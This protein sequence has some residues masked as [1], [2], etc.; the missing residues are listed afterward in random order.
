MNALSDRD[1]LVLQIQRQ[2][3]APSNAPRQHQIRLQRPLAFA[4]PQTNRQPQNEP[5]RRLRPHG[6]ALPAA[7]S[8]ER[9]QESRCESTGGDV[10]SGASG[11]F[12]YTY[13]FHPRDGSQFWR[14][15]DMRMR[16]RIRMR[17]A[18]RR[19][20]TVSLLPLRNHTRCACGFG[21]GCYGAC[22]LERDSRC[23]VSD[24]DE[25]CESLKWLV[26]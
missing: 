24:Q 6:H 22:G 4:L 2:P 17:F 26:A 13:V 25:R 9:R 7:K 8:R 14:L 23:D 11:E 21:Y 20:S 15:D 3:P 12:A 16:M 18:D 10:E 5:P 1:I 19:D